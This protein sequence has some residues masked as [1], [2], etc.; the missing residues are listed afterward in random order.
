LHSGGL[1]ATVTTAQTVGGAITRN[2]NGAGN[3]IWVEIYTIIG[4]T[5]T[6]ITA[7]YTN[8]SGASGQ[9]TEPTTFGGT[10]S[11]DAQRMIQ[12]P[13]A[14]GDT[15]VQSVQSVTVL[16]TTGT[17]GNFG[18]NILRPITVVPVGFTGTGSVRDLISGL[19]GIIE[20][21]TAACLS[22]GWLSNTTTAP[23]IFGSLH[24]IEK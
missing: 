15:G 19:P 16:A 1:S 6:T 22:L 13:L 12:L 5:A 23:Q 21:D 2:T 24:M 10:G 7:S 11:R 18:V 17:A 4:A 8:Q 20:I 14:S 9:I 3:Q